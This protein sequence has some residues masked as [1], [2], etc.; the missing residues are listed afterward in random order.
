MNAIIMKEEILKLIKAK[1]DSLE[2]HEKLYFLDDLLLD[3]YDIE[4]E[5]EEIE[6]EEPRGRI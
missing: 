6:D 3:L 5:L 4:K 1:L 2:P